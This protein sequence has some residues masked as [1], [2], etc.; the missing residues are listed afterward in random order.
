MAT[1][2]NYNCKGSGYIGTSV[3]EVPTNGE[4]G[5]YPPEGTADDDDQDDDGTLQITQARYYCESGSE[6]NLMSNYILEK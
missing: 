2:N 3:L 1:Y 4:C 6:A 5:L